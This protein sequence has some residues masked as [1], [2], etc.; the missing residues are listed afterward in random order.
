MCN[1]QLAGLTATIVTAAALLSG[2]AGDDSTA[3]AAATTTATATTTVT[4]EASSEA[5]APSESASEDASSGGVL[6][7]GQTATVPWGTI[8]L[9]E[10]D[11]DVD[12]DPDVMAGLGHERWVGARVK[13]CVDEGYH[14]EDIK[15]SWSPWSVT[16]TESGVYVSLV[17]I[18]GPSWPQPEYPQLG[19]RTTR[20]G[21][22]AQGWIVF[23]VTDE[24]RLA[25]FVYES[26]SAPEPIV[27]KLK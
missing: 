27:W 14:D 23:A 17:D 15:L 24:A 9:L 2:C 12:S 16:D 4:V 20:P 22:C 10:N 6:E 11:S 5:A 18:T 7:I 26:S 25:E 13:S 19:E 1:Q 8:E 21:T 3:S